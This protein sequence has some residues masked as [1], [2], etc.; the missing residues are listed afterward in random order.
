MKLWSLALKQQTTYGYE[1]VFGNKFV[2]KFGLPCIHVR[3]GAQVLSEESDLTSFL[4]PFLLC[5]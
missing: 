2:P 4:L 3:R 5:V 1:K